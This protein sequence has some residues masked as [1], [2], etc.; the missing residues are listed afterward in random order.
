MG[1]VRSIEKGTQTRYSIHDEMEECTYTTFKD[2]DGNQYLNLKT[3]GSAK[4][5]RRKKQ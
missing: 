1:L 4:R 3:T 2:E 5:K